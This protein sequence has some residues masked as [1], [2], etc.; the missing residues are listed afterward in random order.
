LVF[1]GGA[2]GDGHD[3]DAAGGGVDPA[4]GQRS[5]TDAVLFGQGL[6]DVGAQRQYGALRP[7]HPCVINAGGCCHQA[8]TSRRAGTCRS[9]ASRMVVV[10]SG[11]RAAP[12]P[13][14]VNG[15]AP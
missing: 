8:V 10:A 11:A 4:H 9:A 12:M 6:G 2:A 7:G 13:H 14:P 1:A 5:D 3:V 15:I